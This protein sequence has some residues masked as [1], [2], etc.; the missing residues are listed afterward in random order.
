M[1]HD[2]AIPFLGI[3]P[4]ENVYVQQQSC[5]RMSKAALLIIAQTETMYL[6]LHRQLMGKEVVLELKIGVLHSSF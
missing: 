2:P 1:P 4:T 5:T 6:H 3:Y